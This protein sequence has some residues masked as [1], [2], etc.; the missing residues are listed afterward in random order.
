MPKFIFRGS[1]N[2]VFLNM[3]V[4][5]LENGRYNNKLLP[6]LLILNFETIRWV[7]NGRQ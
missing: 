1:Y 4:K 3:A 7:S 5:M 6:S 2:R